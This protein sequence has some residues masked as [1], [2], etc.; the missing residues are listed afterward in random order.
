[1][2]SL[3]LKELLFY[4]AS[5]VKQV[6]PP[7]SSYV[8]SLIILKTIE[9]AEKAPL[10]IAIKNSRAFHEYSIQI[11]EK[12]GKYYPII[13]PGTIWGSSPLKYLPEG[14]TFLLDIH[15]HPEA[16]F[17]PNTSD[18]HSLSEYLVK[19]KYYGVASRYNDFI[20]FT[21]IR[22]DE[23]IRKIINQL[24]EILKELNKYSKQSMKVIGYAPVIESIYS[25]SYETN[26]E[27]QTHECIK[28]AEQVYQEIPNIRK[29]LP[30][31]L[32]KVLDYVN[33]QITE[34]KA[35]DIISVYAMPIPRYEEYEKYSIESLKVLRKFLIRSLLEVSIKI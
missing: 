14:Y 5:I 15:T 17:V 18:I 22:Y 3:S 32:N 9:E 33:K 2:N 23:V 26:E 16:D 31:I 7:Y 21:L 11:L 30:L 25:A 34:I 10:D 12:E 35:K 20:K 4:L 1:M 28:I 19:P 27:Y 6:V 8:N 13:K 29:A 24:C